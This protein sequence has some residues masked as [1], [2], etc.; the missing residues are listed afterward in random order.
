MVS[1][2]EGGASRERRRQDRWLKGKMMEVEATVVCLSGSRLVPVIVNV[3]S[4]SCHMRGSVCHLAATRARATGTRTG[5]SPLYP[6][7][8]RF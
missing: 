4:Q 7:D 5:V 3:T 2:P 8:S 1:R 6:H